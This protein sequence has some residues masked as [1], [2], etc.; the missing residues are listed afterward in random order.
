MNF[1]PGAVRVWADTLTRNDQYLTHQIVTSGAVGDKPRIS[2]TFNRLPRTVGSASVP[3]GDR[4]ALVGSAKSKIIGVILSKIHIKPKF[5]SGIRIRTARVTPEVTHTSLPGVRPSTQHRIL[6]P[7]DPYIKI[8]HFRTVPLVSSPGR[9]LPEVT[10]YLKLVTSG[11]VG[12][13][14]VSPG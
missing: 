11:A 2:R 5:P 14:P 4:A 6:A 8:G 1:G 3:A 12:A 7:D 9:I 10:H 13:N